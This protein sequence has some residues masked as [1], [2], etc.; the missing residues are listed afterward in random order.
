MSKFFIDRPIFAWVI[1]I[2]VMIGGLL[3]ILK[4]PVSQYP[5]IAPV[6]V[7]I[8]ASYVGAPTTVMEETVVQIIE[9]QMNGLDGLRYL[10]SEANSDGSVNVTLT[11]DQGTDPDI[12]QVQVQNK[13]QLALPSLPM[14]VQQAGI[15]V[16]KA[17]DSTLMVVGL[18]SPDGTYNKQDLADYIVAHIHFHNISLEKASLL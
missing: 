18:I 3:S 2:S 9:H 1:A 14:E 7:S 16:K 4:L 12:A 17:T 11:F 15:S 8:S 6:T 13:L 5:G 10:T